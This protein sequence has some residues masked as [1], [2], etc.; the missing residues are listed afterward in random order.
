M[1]SEVG[2]EPTRLST[3]GFE[4]SVSTIPPFRQILQTTRRRDS[5][6]LRHRFS[7]KA[8]LLFVNRAAPR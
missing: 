2:F 3:L 7:F 4:P 1:V 6:R 8:H 5:H